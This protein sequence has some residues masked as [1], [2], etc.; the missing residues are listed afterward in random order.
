[1]LRN[2]KHTLLL[3]GA[4]LCAATSH[5]QV[6]SASGSANKSTLT[7]AADNIVT[8]TWNVTTTTDRLS[9]MVSVANTNPPLVWNVTLPP[10]PNNSEMITISA[11][12]V[13]TWLDAGYKVVIVRR[14]FADRFGNPVGGINADIRLRL[15]DAN[16]S[17]SNRRGESVF[18]ITRMHLTFDNQANVALIAPE[19]ELKAKLNVNYNGTGLLEGFWEVAEP[20]SSE[21]VPIFRRLQAVQQPLSRGQLTQLQSPLLPTARVGKYLLR[22]CVISRATNQTVCGEDAGIVQAVYQVQKSSAGLIQSIKSQSAGRLNGDA[23]LQWQALPEAVVYQLQVFTKVGDS[24]VFVT[25]MLLPKEQHKTKLSAAMME[26]LATNTPYQW[27]VN[28]LGSQG[29]LLGQSKLIDFLYI[30]E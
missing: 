30:A 2:M 14:N 10:E 4:L 20:G 29:Q 19:S 27:R 25:G 6:T 17:L 28:A 18:Q 16:A 3:V 15:V 22:F 13:Q 11:A 5:A 24:S 1:M 23:E 12:Q 7:N 26:K 8:L 9:A 21:G